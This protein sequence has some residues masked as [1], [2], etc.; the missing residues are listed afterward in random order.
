MAVE[1]DWE[2]F[3]QEQEAHAC[4]VSQHTSDDPRLKPY[5]EGDAAWWARCI[6]PICGFDTGM[7]M[8]CD[9]WAKYLSGGINTL[10]CVGCTR[11]SQ[12]KDFVKLLEKMKG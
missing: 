9:R 7:R 4:E 3:E 2:L 11:V 6:C 1:L 5:H 12:C 8:V 10:L